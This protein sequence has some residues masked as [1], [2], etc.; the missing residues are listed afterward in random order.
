MSDLPST[1]V[2]DLREPRFLANYSLGPREA[3]RAA[4]AQFEKKDWNTWDY[5]KYD[6]LVVEGEFTFSCGNFVAFKDRTRDTGLDLDPQVFSD[7]LT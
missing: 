5:A 6:S 7:K 1:D 4:Y 3:V 2:H